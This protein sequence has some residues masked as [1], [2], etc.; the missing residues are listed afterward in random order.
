MKSHISQSLSTG[1]K[2]AYLSETDIEN[3]SNIE[4]FYNETQT[5]Y[6]RDISAPFQ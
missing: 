2:L 5:N 3:H 6:I 4:L 1:Q